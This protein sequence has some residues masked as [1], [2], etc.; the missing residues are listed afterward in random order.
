MPNKSGTQLVI[1]VCGRQW[2]EWILNHKELTDDEHKSWVVVDGFRE[3]ISQDYQIVTAGEV[4]ES[5]NDFIVRCF[6]N[7]PYE[8]QKNINDRFLK[9]MIDKTLNGIKPRTMFGKLYDQGMKFYNVYSYGAF[10]LDL[11]KNPVVMTL[12][13]E[14][15]TGFS[16][17]AYSSATS[18]LMYWTSLL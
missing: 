10:A 14:Y 15:F 18:A 12:V 3:K 17:L 9:S 11:A 4:K 6:Q 2:G 8:Q 7:V 1:C 5:V 13:A 16:V